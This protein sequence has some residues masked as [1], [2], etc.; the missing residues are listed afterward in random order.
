MAL[1]TVS[2]TG[3]MSVRLAVFVIPAKGYS[4]TRKQLKQIYVRPLS[5][6]SQSVLDPY[7]CYG[8]PKI[9]L[10]ADQMR[11]LREFFADV[12]DPRRK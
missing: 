6:R 12:N 9:I 2:Q 11:T 8:A 3:F 1:S 5:P 4:S 10:M 7:Y